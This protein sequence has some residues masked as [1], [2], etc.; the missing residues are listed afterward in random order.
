MKKAYENIF[1]GTYDDPAIIQDDYET[2]VSYAAAVAEEDNAQVVK[3]AAVN[4][5]KYK[6]LMMIS[7]WEWTSPP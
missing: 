4:V 6:I 7:S 5:K 2:V 1:N 3:D